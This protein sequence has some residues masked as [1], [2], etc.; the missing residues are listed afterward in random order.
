MSVFKVLE[1]KTFFAAAHSWMAVF[2]KFSNA[3]CS[4]L[5]IYR[6][7]QVCALQISYLQEIRKPPPM[8]KAKLLSPAVALKDGKSSDGNFERLLIAF[9]VT[10]FARGI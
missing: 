1:I 6:F 3:K 4:P 2:K 9:E 10:D 5:K 8:P 7:L